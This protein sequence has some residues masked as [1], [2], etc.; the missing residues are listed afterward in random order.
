MLSACCR[1]GLILF[2]LGAITLVAPG[3][4]STGPYAPASEAARDPAKAQRLTLE[5][6]KFM[7]TNPAKAERLVR[8]ALGADLY[9]GPAHNNLGVIYLA[10]GRLYEAAGE[11]EWA[12]KLMPGHPDPRVNLAMVLEQAG[13]SDDA[14]AAYS[15]ALETR[16]GYLPAMQGLARLQVRT[17]RTDART[18]DLLDEIAMQAEDA[19]WR[20]WARL[21][22]LKL[23]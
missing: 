7:E 3:C 20:D 1:D 12:K 5:A 8:E 4:R 22:R 6:A 23:E 9:H 16:P 2:V 15:A 14:L 13:R 11:F 17:G 19:A 21:A 10:Q 18:L